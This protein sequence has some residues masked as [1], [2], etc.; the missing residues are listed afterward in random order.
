MSGKW[1]KEGRDRAVE[2]EVAWMLNER[3]RGVYGAARGLA[4]VVSLRNCGGTFESRRRLG[5]ADCRARAP[6]PAEEGYEVKWSAPWCTDSAVA[7]AAPFHLPIW[8]WLTTYKPPFPAIRREWP[9]G[10]AHAASPS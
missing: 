1:G 9:M 3:D 4:D 2:L 5:G 7:P 6:S 10:R 8:L